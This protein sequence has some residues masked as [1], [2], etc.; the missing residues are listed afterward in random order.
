MRVIGY[1]AFEWSDKVNPQ[2]LTATDNAELPYVLTP[3]AE[4]WGWETQVAVN[5]HGLRDREFSESKGHRHRIAAI[6]DS[7]TF[8]SRLSPPSVLYPKQLEQLL[9]S[10]PPL[11]DAE[12]LN[13]G[14][15]GYDVANNVKHLNVRALK[16]DPDLVLLGFCVNDIGTSS[17]AMGYIR[18][19]KYLAHPLFQVRAAQFVLSAGLKLTATMQSNDDQNIEVFQR[20]NRSRMRPI[21]DDVE[22]A[23]MIDRLE[24][25]VHDRS[26]RG[27][28]QWWT[29][30]PRIEFLEYGFHKLRELKLRHGFE[31]VVV[32]VPC[33]TSA[34]QSGGGSSIR[35]F[36]TNR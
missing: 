8:G 20:I 36:G 12:V 31:V 22:L 11:S 17:T 16:F 9:R 33:S 35:S 25:L 29:Q 32:A 26:A 15:S 6:G 27:L 10:R 18:A 21:A 2:L 5:S 3:N 13:F 23:G 1:Q 14:V 28:L 24:N 30:R 4:G 7:I 19:A 34:T